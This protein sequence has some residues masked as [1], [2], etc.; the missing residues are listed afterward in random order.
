MAFSSRRARAGRMSRPG[1]VPMPNKESRRTG[2]GVPGPKELPG[3][4]V[5]VGPAAYGVDGETAA[6]LLV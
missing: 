1:Q 2:T 3:L 5:P 6:P 4:P